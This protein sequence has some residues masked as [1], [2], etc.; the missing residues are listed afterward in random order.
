MFTDYRLQS[1]DRHFL[2][3]DKQ[4]I[5]R[6]AASGRIGNGHFQVIKNLPA[7]LVKKG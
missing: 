3:L 1:H 7:S 2:I 5:I 4:G 6:Y